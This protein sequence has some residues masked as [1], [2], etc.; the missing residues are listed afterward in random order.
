MR[1]LITTDLYLPAVNGVVTSV[2]S[3][4]RGLQQRGHE[5]RIVTLSDSVHT[6]TEGNVT[7]I[8]S[9]PAGFIYPGVRARVAPLGRVIRDLV[10]WHPD[11]VHSQCEFGTFGIARKVAR[12]CGAVL[13]H[14]Y[15]TVYEDYT[16]YFCPSARV[17]RA[18]AAWLTR[19]IAGKTDG[20]IAPTE[21]VEQLLGSYRVTAPVS[22]IPTGAELPARE[23]ITPAERAATRRAFGLPPEGRLLLYLG[24]LAEEKNIGALFTMLEAPDL[25]GTLLVL[26]G[27]GP[28]R[29]VLREEVRRL[30][31]TERVRF[32]GMIPHA[33]VNRVYR[34]A[35]VFVNAS[36]SETQG[37]TYAEAMAAGLPVVCRADPCVAGLI[38]N[39]ETGFACETEAE[40]AV[41]V[42]RLLTEETLRRRIVAAARETIDRT[43]SAAAFAA[44]VEQLYL[45]TI[46]AHGR[47]ADV[48]GTYPRRLYDH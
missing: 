37:L 4:A 25:C 38:V 30:G 13:L 28:Y 5:V 12:K 44:A 14:T 46:A 15:H 47:C 18:L 1:I 17:G 33:E 26:A 48:N 11:V 19:R 10:L 31:L 42:R 8:G 6:H 9:V 27:D 21:K 23:T 3:L 43:Y 2:V 24:R 29:G 16:H 39:G 40:M 32:L 36:R 41:A 7:Y 45:R 35:D 22:V 20:I 34:M